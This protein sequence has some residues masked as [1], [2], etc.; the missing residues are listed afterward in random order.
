MGKDY[1]TTIVK[2]VQDNGD[3]TTTFELA[4]KYRES[5]KVR[6][7]VPLPLSNM[8]NRGDRVIFCNSGIPLGKREEPYK[9]GHENYESVAFYQ[10]RKRKPSLSISGQRLARFEGA[11]KLTQPI[12]RL[13]ELDRGLT[14]EDAANEREAIGG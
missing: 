4:I 8:V 14:A 6:Y 9:V 7:N 11:L 10:G 2:E 13:L 12:S 5:T 3:E 1:L